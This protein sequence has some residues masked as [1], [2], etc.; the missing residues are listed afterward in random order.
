MDSGMNADEPEL[1][2]HDSVAPIVLTYRR[3]FRKPSFAD[4]T[5]FVGVW[6]F[7]KNMGR[8]VAALLHECAYHT[9]RETL[10]PGHSTVVHY[11]LNIR[12]PWDV[13]AG[14]GELV[15]TNHGP[16]KPP[17]AL[18]FTVI[19][20]TAEAM[21]QAHAADAAAAQPINT[22]LA[23]QVNGAH[24]PTNGIV[25]TNGAVKVNGALEEDDAADP[26][27]PVLGP[28][29]QIMNSAYLPR[30]V[31]VADPSKQQILSSQELGAK[32]IRESLN[33]HRDDFI[34]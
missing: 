34:Q 13:T 16:D 23:H 2:I 26:S 18:N 12:D 7:A 21:A 25:P 10:D 31:Q 30:K 33:D 15:A 32:R 4:K 28:D 17:S 9:E 24:P 14:E 19:S 3:V 22:N 11:S 8:K 5:T 20:M 27:G 1:A 6:G 29:G